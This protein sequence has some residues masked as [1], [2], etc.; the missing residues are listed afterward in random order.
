MAAAKDQRALS[1]SGSIGEEPLANLN[2]C[3]MVWKTE[4]ILD[5]NEQFEWFREAS[6]DGVGFQGGER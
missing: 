4:G 6:F 2:V 5:V 3:G 1:S